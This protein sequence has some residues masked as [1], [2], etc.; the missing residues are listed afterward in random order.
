MGIAGEWRQDGGMNQNG[1]VIQDGDA[2]YKLLHVAAGEGLYTEMRRKDT[3]KR[4]K[5]TDTV[6]GV[7]SFQRPGGYQ[8]NLI[9]RPILVPEIS[10]SSPLHY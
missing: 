3:K 6:T 2:Q 1:G 7:G 8:N 9:Q 10:K 5:N 4:G